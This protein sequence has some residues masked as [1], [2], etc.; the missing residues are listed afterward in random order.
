MLGHSIDIM[1]KM[2]RVRFAVRG[3]LCD[4]SWAWKS[5][6]EVEIEREIKT[7][8]SSWCRVGMLGRLSE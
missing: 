8:L 7:D 5:L 3:F 1:T 6:P 4:N 2:A